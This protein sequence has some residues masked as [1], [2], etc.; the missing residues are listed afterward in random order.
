MLICQ[1][2]DTRL[3][4]DDRDTL[5]TVVTL[6]VI[7]LRRILTHGQHFPFLLAKE[8]EEGDAD[9]WE[10]RVWETCD[11]D[12]WGTT[13]DLVFPVSKDKDIVKSVRDVAEDRQ[14]KYIV[15]PEILRFSRQVLEK[16]D[17]EEAPNECIRTLRELVSQ[18]HQE[19]DTR[20][21]SLPEG[22]MSIGQQNLA[23]QMG[24]CPMR[25]A[26]VSSWT[27]HT[28][29]ERHKGNR[30]W[31]STSIPL[32]WADPLPLLVIP[33]I[34]QVGKAMCAVMVIR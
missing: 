14:T 15:S 22:E 5:G 18:W 24:W 8:R 23:T 11:I 33:G 19:E 34:P 4:G 17:L 21:S 2:A 27:G 1:P 20:D 31:E 30:G 26:W 10:T 29:Q 7:D 6:T 25:N 16:E 32:Q 9:H 3:R 28:D 13:G 12:V